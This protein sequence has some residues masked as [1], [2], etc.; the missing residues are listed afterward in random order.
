MC[1]SLYVARLPLC[2]PGKSPGLVC[3]LLVVGTWGL[4]I[5][6]CECVTSQVGCQGPGGKGFL[7]MCSFGPCVSALILHYLKTG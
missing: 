5:L 4:V 3:S 2:S 1:G 6:G 7:A